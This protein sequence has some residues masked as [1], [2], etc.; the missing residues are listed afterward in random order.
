MDTKTALSIVTD[1]TDIGNEPIKMHIKWKQ[2]Y[3]QLDKG[4]D[5][6]EWKL[7]FDLGK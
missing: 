7:L 1:H 3:C 5:V 2:H 4:V 6:Y